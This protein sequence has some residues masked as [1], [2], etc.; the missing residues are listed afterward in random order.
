MTMLTYSKAEIERISMPNNQSNYEYLIKRRDS[1][2]E[3]VR[4]IERGWV[5]S[6]PRLYQGRLYDLF[7]DKGD[8]FRIAHSPSDSFPGYFYGYTT[9][10]DSW[11]IGYYTESIAE[12]EEVERARDNEL[13]R[14]LKKLIREKKEQ[15]RYELRRFDSEWIE[16]VRALR[17]T[18]KQLMAFYQSY[19]NDSTIKFGT[20]KSKIMELKRSFPYLRE[21]QNLL[22][23]TIDSS[24]HYVSQFKLNGEDIINEKIPKRLKRQTRERDDHQCVRCGNENDLQIHHV[25]PLA[26][27]GDHELE[28]LAT[29]CEDCHRMAHKGRQDKNGKIRGMEYSKISYDSVD[30]FWNDW[31]DA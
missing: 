14:E 1:L 3:E 2:N 15:V 11:W 23:S 7:G 16:K 10:D 25:I 28:N 19:L 24:F 8:D 21:N 12:G 4:D 6:L 17:N 31:V 9:L 30:E 20:K 27:G 29:L 13:I 26:R 22:A 18:E 5:E